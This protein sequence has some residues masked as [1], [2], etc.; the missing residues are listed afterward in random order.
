MGSDSAV[1]AGKDT[2]ASCLAN[3]D[4]QLQILP[5][6]APLVLG[7]MQQLGIISLMR[8]SLAC[9]STGNL[10]ANLRRRDLQARGMTVSKSGSTGLVGPPI[11]WSFTLKRSTTKIQ[12]GDPCRST[13]PQNRQD[14]E[15]Q[16]GSRPFLGKEC[17]DSPGKGRSLVR[18][19]RAQPRGRPC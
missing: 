2:Y 7:D 16:H 10:P 19:H 18:G 8:G 4:R 17:G 3:P 1:L 12:C 9:C 13:D 15:A 6:G 11:R 5:L 14:C